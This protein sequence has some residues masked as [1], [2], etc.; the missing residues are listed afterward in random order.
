MTDKSI[1]YDVIQR[2]EQWKQEATD[3]QHPNYGH[4]DLDQPVGMYTAISGM[5]EK[6]RTTP[7]SFSRDDVVALFGTLNAG[8]RMKNKVADENPLAE[9]QEQLIALL[10]GDGAPAAK[11][12]AA[13]NGIRFAGPSML[14]ELYGWAHVDT[15]P[16]YNDCATEALAYLGYEFAPRDYDAF[17][18]A[19]EQFKRVYQQHVGHLRP[20]LPLNLEI[21]KLYNVI[22]KVD[23]KQPPEVLAFPFDEMF[24]DLEEVKW[25]FDLLAMAATRLGLEGPE[26][27]IAAFNLRRR[28]G[29][30][31]L[32][33]SYGTWLVLGFSGNGGS[34]NGVHLALLA[35]RVELVPLEKQEFAQKPTEAQVAL[36]LFAAEAVHPLPDDIRAT[37]EITLDHIKERFSGRQRSLHRQA[38]KPQIAA[39]VFDRAAR[40]RLLREGIEAESQRFWKIAPGESAWNWDACR[41]GGFIAIGWDELGDISGMSREEFVALRDELAAELEDWTPAGADQAWNFA[42]IQEGDRIVANRGT[43]EILGIGTVTGSYYYVEGQR[44]GHRLPVHWDDVTPRQISEPGWRRTLIEL[45]PAKF[46]ALSQMPSEFV[47][48]S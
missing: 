21:D 32:R 27:P 28:G 22:D 40:D 16:L 17:V 47:K 5:L 33:L 37:Y 8:Q 26:D 24:R 39:A 4:A 23:L 13:S 2:L 31:H 48:I 38:N 19:H 18:A 43:T 10:Y 11:I 12:A 30:Y 36:H 44:H 45:E 46:E 41:E 1:N 7:E 35:D 29:A 34:L 42:Q 6:L 14:G 15:A 20:D 9:L 3:P 25:A